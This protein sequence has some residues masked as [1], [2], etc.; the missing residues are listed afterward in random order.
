MANADWIVAVA[1]ASTSGPARGAGTLDAGAAAVDALPRELGDLSAIQ[2]LLQVMPVADLTFGAGV[3]I[4]IMLIHAAGVRT[5]ANY[6]RR[7]TLRILARPA[8]WRADVLMSS[9]VFLL[10]ALHVLEI[11]VWAAALVLA[12]LVPD[13][14]TAGLFAGNTYTTLGY[15]AYVLPRGWGMMSPLIAI[16]GLF[17][18]GWSGSVL[19]D[20]VARCQKI[21]DATS[22]GGARNA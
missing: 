6:V 11:I 10:L 14:R 21:K 7:S 22:P 2:P 12:G 16:S 15:G 1:E 13:W 19:V 17:T 5:V 20:L 3:L 8:S 4:V 18:F 9:A